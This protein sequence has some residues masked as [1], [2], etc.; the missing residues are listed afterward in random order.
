[1]FGRLKDLA[2][3]YA[4][5]RNTKL[6]SIKSSIRAVQTNK[7]LSTAASVTSSVASHTAPPVART[8]GADAYSYIDTAYDENINNLAY[9]AVLYGTRAYVYVAG[10]LTNVPTPVGR[11]D[12]V[13]VVA[14]ILDV[15][16][17]DPEHPRNNPAGY[18]GEA[19]DTEVVEMFDDLEDHMDIYHRQRDVIERRAAKKRVGDDR[20]EEVNLYEKATPKQSSQL[21]T[22]VKDGLAGDGWEMIDEEDQIDSDTEA[23]HN[24]RLSDSDSSDI[25]GGRHRRRRPS[26][27]SDVAFPIEN[28]TLDEAEEREEM[29]RLVL[30]TQ[31]QKEEAD[32]AA[33]GETPLALGDM[34]EKCGFVPSLA[35]MQSDRR[36]GQLARES[37]L[38]A[39]KAKYA[40]TADDIIANKR[41]E[42]EQYEAK[43]IIGTDDIMTK[44]AEETAHYKAERNSFVSEGGQMEAKM[45]KPGASANDAATSPL[46]TTTVSAPID[47]PGAVPRERKE[48]EEARSHSMEMNLAV[49]HAKSEAESQEFGEYE[50]DILDDIPFYPH[51]LRQQKV[52]VKTPSATPSA[53]M[54]TSAAVAKD[55]EYGEESG[56]DVTAPVKRQMSASFERNAALLVAG[57]KAFEERMEDNEDSEDSGDS[58]DS[59]DSEDSEDSEDDCSL[60]EIL[61]RKLPES[62]VLET[63]EGEFN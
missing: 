24:E 52:T 21:R 13:D 42:T 25:S 18:V 47:I 56:D 8:A 51:P 36:A 55:Y 26:N 31:W 9:K 32:R 50:D 35:F 39:E 63:E 16:S 53:P 23:F 41:Q 17:P 4:P 11:V 7:F 58:G 1:M 62:H 54:P 30:Q 20:L 59:G 38:K 43:S 14:T 5:D 27:A 2:A 48:K 29:D 19:C 33:G 28:L 6:P 15:I 57:K 60:S 10:K 37:Q 34:M 46:R 61:A 49:A 40:A 44:M 3:S 12:V 22:V 45:F